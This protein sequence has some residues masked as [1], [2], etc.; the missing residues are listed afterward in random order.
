MPENKKFGKE[1][2]SYSNNLTAH[3]LNH[4]TYLLA[5]GLLSMT[6]PAP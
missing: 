6:L 1:S 3:F 2:C 4:G 5:Y